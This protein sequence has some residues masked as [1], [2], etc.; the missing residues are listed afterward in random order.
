MNADPGYRTESRGGRRSK[1]R[2]RR[3]IL[4]LLVLAIPALLLWGYLEGPA[5]MTIEDGTTLHVKIAG[6]Y[7]ESQAPSL[8]SRALGERSRPFLSLLST[9][10]LAESDDRIDTVILHFRSVDMGWGKAG[11]VRDQISRLR[12][13]G[14]KTIAYL[15]L[16]GLSISREYYV[17]T[18]ADEIYVMPGSALP[19]VG[20]GAEY[21]YLGGAWEKLGLRFATSKAGKYKSAVESL[22]GEGMSEASREMANSLLDSI[23]GLFIGAIAKG[24]GKTADEVRRIID[25]AP[26]LAGQLLERGLID[27]VRHFSQIPE[28]V[29]PMVEG[30]DYRKLDPK[31]L[32]FDPVARLALI[33]GSGNVVTGS[34][35]RTVGGDAVFSSER[36]NKALAAAV[37]DPSIDGIVLRID[38]GGGS[39]MASEMMWDAMR[40]TRASGKP[41]IASFSDVAAS[42]AYYVA[43]AADAI[44]APPGSLTGSI[45]V[46]VIRP[47]V[48]EL[49]DR[50][51]I[52]VET[53]TR[54]PHADFLSVTQPLS[55]ASDQR[56]QAITLAIYDLFLKRVSE[57]RGLEIAEVDAVAQGR[58]WTGEQALQAHLVDELGGLQTA[59][60]VALEKLGHER[61]DD[62]LLVP[63]PQAPSFAEEI[64]QILRGEASVSLGARSLVREAVEGSLPLPRE[65]RVVASWLA[66]LPYD[67]PLLIPSS[68]VEI[69]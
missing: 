50:L 47:V 54:G 46:F 69:R 39:A 11:E 26:V 31:S 57:G 6:R 48:D 44:V 7:V 49:L 16:G 42:G 66:E 12:E 19:L 9:L 15:E 68:W 20:L 3:R 65:L 10:S 1:P 38:S 59:V 18:A 43:S 61:D 33:Y 67:A 53:L 8:I 2:W 13:S 63:F 60:E 24:R 37:E 41:V 14:K 23:D 35:R 58:V 25:A 4:I 30:E 64:S 22:T 5:P 45:G 52:Q 32:G 27:G 28:A 40:T 51:G 36:T 17:A 55:A 34:A 62:V 29:G 56:M 21:F